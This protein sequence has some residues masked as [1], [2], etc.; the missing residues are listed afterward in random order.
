MSAKRELGTGKNWARSTAG[1][2]K[3]WK[4]RG[5]VGELILSR[6]QEK[7]LRIKK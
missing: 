2:K 3:G 4:K 1:S 6:K 5:E 7:Q